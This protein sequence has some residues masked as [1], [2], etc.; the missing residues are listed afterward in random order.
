MSTE[1]EDI[2]RLDKSHIS[3]AI[4]VLSEAFRKYPLFNYYYP[5]ELTKERIVNYFLSFAVYGGM[6]YGEVYAT[7]NNL[8][9]VAV[10]MPSDG[11]HMN[12]LRLLRSVPL[13]ILF[14]FGR[15]GGKNMKSLGEHLD[16]V[17][18]HNA[19]FKHWYLW[20]VG[21]APDFKG[22]GYASKLIRPMLTR[23]GRDR[24]PC[25]LETIDEKNVPIY[26]HLGFKV[27]D[28]SNVPNTSLIN[29]AM[30][31]EI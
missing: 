7:S 2:L 6:R 5:D 11:Y 18:K 4:K 27:V 17:H 21:V 19:P 25:Y 15:Y 14:G 1:L 9:G 23:T 20:M 8:E 24:L 3:S 30:L 16:A 29:W 26:E 22:K 10:W 28:K 12:L 13:S 31:R